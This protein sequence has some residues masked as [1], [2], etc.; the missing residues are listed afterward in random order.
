MPNLLPGF[1]KSLIGS[2]TPRS[3][4]GRKTDVVGRDASED[5]LLAALDIARLELLRLGAVPKII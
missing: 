1:L 3:F 2:M 5:D 4:E